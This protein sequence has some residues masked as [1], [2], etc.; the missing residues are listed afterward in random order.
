MGGSAPCV[1]GGISKTTEQFEFGKAA[2]LLNNFSSSGA[3]RQI[4]RSDGYLEFVGGTV[5][6]YANGTCE[7]MP[8]SEA[9]HTRSQQTQIL[10]QADSVAGNGTHSDGDSVTVM[11]A[12]NSHDQ[13][14]KW[15]KMVVG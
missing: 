15:Q 4:S 2:W 7:N 1:T 5:Y 6:K 13:F 12:T 10:Q 8:N 9:K 14:Q 3:G 11:A